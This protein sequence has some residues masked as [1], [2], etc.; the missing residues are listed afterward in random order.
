MSPPNPDSRTV[1]SLD[2]LIAGFAKISGHAAVLSRLNEVL[3]DEDAGAADLISVLRVDVGLTARVIA[4]ANT[5]YFRR[6]SR[7][8]SVEEA[9][10]RVGMAQIRRLLLGSIAYELTTGPM[11]AYGFGPGEVWARS[12]ACAVA[13]EM[14]AEETQRSGDACRTIGLMHALGMIVIDRWVTQRGVR[15]QALPRPGDDAAVEQFE[16]GQVGVENAAVCAHLLETWKFPDACVEAVRHQRRPLEAGV[17]QRLACLLA[18]ARWQ[19]AVVQAGH[20]MR[21]WPA[22]PGSDVLAGAGLSEESLK[23]L[24]PMVSA[25]FARQKA[26]FG[27]L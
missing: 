24:L 15:G 26:E 25:E 7:V 13:M 2:E 18:L 20:D 22:V 21:R 23:A 10:I 16:M 11:R 1:P 4:A 19:T 9:V 5:V 6:G 17:F 8:A 12:L 14:L 27:L 3:D